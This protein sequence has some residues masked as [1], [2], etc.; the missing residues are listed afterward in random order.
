MCIVCIINGKGAFVISIQSS[1]RIS[2]EMLAS[3]RLVDILFCSCKLYSLALAV[4]LQHFHINM[5]YA[6]VSWVTP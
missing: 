4:V 6:N 2:D 1:V 3:Q 5:L